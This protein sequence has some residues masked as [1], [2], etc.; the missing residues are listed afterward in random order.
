MFRNEARWQSHK[1][2]KWYHKKLLDSTKN[3]AT[4]FQQKFSKNAKNLLIKTNL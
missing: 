4:D 1:F 3:L 2:F